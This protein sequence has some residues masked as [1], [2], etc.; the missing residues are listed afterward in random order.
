M[1]LKDNKETVSTEHVVKKQE[2]VKEEW[3]SFFDLDNSVTVVSFT[4]LKR[5]DW[6]S[7]CKLKLRGLWSSLNG[8]VK[9]AFG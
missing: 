7:F 3:V 9:K 6:G 8:D 2:K 4:E 1:E 5:T